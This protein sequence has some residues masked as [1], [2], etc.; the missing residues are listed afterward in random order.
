MWR[1]LVVRVWVHHELRIGRT[2]WEGMAHVS[3]RD[4]ATHGTRMLLLV[5]MMVRVVPHGSRGA[6]HVTT[7]HFLL[8]AL[9]VIHPLMPRMKS[10]VSH[11]DILHPNYGINKPMIPVVEVLPGAGRA[12]DCSTA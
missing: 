6:S 1:G 8:D 9:I 3:G 10:R 2:E 4:V 5:L 11:G 7:H 12:G